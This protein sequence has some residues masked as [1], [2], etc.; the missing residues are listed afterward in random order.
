MM[1]ST[2]YIPI[3]ISVSKTLTPSCQ[4]LA[5]SGFDGASSLTMDSPNVPS[6]QLLIR[7]WKGHCLG[8]ASVWDMRVTVHECHGPRLLHIMQG[9]R[10]ARRSVSKSSPPGTCSKPLQSKPQTPKT[11][12]QGKPQIIPT[13][14][15]LG[16]WS[17]KWINL[18]SSR[19]GMEPTDFAVLAQ[20]LSFLSHIR[21]T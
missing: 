2:M 16:Q 21:Q 11:R 15:H 17:L 7:S 20:L 10:E 19:G 5:S 12:G 6:P 4:S 8:D 13:C 9:T 14:S 3:R 18:F 1:G